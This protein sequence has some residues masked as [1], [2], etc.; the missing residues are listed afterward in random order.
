MVVWFQR[1]QLFAQGL[2]AM[3]VGDRD[4]LLELVLPKKAKAMSPKIAVN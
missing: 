1:A 4:G 2:R 3:D